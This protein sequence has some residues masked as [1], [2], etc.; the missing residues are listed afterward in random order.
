MLGL[1]NLKVCTILQAT[2]QV[3]VTGVIISDG[4]V[5]GRGSRRPITKDGASELPTRLHS[6]DIASGTYA[7][8]LMVLVVSCRTCIAC[9]PVDLGNMILVYTV[10]C[11]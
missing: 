3:T 8:V 9:D 4:A 11:C 6:T 1:G 10:G 5:V 7:G 2:V